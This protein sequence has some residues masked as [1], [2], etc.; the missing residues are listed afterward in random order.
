VVDCES[1]RAED[2]HRQWIGTAAAVPSG[3]S[4]A[5]QAAGGTIY[6]DRVTSLDVPRQ[7][8]LLTAIG[9]WPASG[10]S[11]QVPAPRLLAGSRVDPGSAAAQG[12]LIEPL[13]ERLSGASIRMPALRER[14]EDIGLLTHHF[15]AAIREINQLP[16]LTVSA[17][18]LR[19]LERYRWPAN[20]RELRNA[21]E[22]AV[23]LAAEGS[24]R[25]QDLPDKIREEQPATPT[26]VRHAAGERFR[27]AKRAVVDSFEHA[28]LSDLLERH[29]GNVTSASQHAGMLRSALQ[30]LL[31][32]HGLKSAEF[33]TAHATKRQRS[34]AESDRG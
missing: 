11:G 21:V 34:E 28:Y 13:L 15:V 10:G 19:L 17:D 8:E 33:R 29:G 26:G 1:S 24:I 7:E 31:R 14:I 16:P 20:V 3:S 32:K 6:L 5:H 23:I 22:H 30:R 12:W 27:D 18:A 9:D 4:V 2:W 25:P